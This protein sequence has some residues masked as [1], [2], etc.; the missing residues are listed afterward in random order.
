MKTDLI[1]VREDTGIDRAIALMTRH[2]IKRLPVVDDQGIFKGMI[3]R[4][5]LLKQGFST[6]KGLMI[7]RD[8]TGPAGSMN[9]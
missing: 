1:T 8:K 2:G 6:M 9:L 4:E 7:P 5:A 3:S